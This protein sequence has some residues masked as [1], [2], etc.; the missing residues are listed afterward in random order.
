MGVDAKVN[1]EG[2]LWCYK[3]TDSWRRL[4]VVIRKTAPTI[5]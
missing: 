2:V 5:R 1:A 3:G 4:E